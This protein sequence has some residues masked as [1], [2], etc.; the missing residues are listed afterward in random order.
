[1][2]SFKPSR[3]DLAVI[4]QQMQAEGLVERVLH[5]GASLADLEELAQGDNFFA[6]RE[7]GEIAAFWWLTH[8]YASAWCLHGCAFKKHRRAAFA[9]MEEL[10][11]LLAAQGL[12]DL[13]AFSEHRDVA[14]FLSRLGFQPL[15]K[16][17]QRIRLW[18]KVLRI[19]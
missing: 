4:Y 8:F 12:T 18:V 1:M 17:K 15:N 5:G 3:A 2:H 16:I 6:E 10:F 9:R 14:I 13:Y 19:P 7:G 11:G